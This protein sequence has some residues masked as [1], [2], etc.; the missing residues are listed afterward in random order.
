MQM[1]MQG[2]AA[3]Q[4]SMLKHGKPRRKQLLLASAR[5]KNQKRQSEI[6]I[7]VRLLKVLN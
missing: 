7:L 4:L 6:A 2:I 5:M 1:Q 3:V